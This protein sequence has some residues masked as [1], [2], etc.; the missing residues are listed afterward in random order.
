[1]AIP[2]IYKGADEVI[3]ITLTDADGNPL[4]VSS[5]SEVV[6][7]I[8]QVKE[9]VIQQWK[10]SD[11]TLITVSSSGGIVQA[12]FDRDNSDTVPL[13]RLYLEV[14]AQI[15]DANFEGGFQRMIASDIVLAD[16][17]NSVV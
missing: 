5:L 7:S 17:K 8:Y 12:N 15:A 9:T 16:L 4:V 10:K 2:I 1:M 11:N 13:K 3:N 14:V 6:V